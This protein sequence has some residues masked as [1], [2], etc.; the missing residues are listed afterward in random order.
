[1]GYKAG[2]LPQERPRPA[3]LGGGV[4]AVGIPA[5]HFLAVIAMSHR[6]PKRRPSL[7]GAQPTKQSHFR[8][9]TSLRWRL[10]HSERA[11]KTFGRA[12]RASLHSR[13]TGDRE[14]STQASPRKPGRAHLP[15]PRRALTPRIFKPL[16]LQ[17]AGFLRTI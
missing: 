3:R 10:T 16:R 13:K 6:A 5:N 8:R 17:S 9:Q 12:N 15:A 7:R 14:R 11:W 4:E 1:M 2:Y